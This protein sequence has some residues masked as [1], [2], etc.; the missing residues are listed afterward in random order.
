MNN[1]ARGWPCP[2]L[3]PSLKSLLSLTEEELRTDTEEAL[4][5]GEDA[6]S[7]SMLD[8]IASLRKQTI[9]TNQILITNG[10]SQG[11][12]ICCS[13]FC[14]PGD[15]I[16]VETLSYFYAKYIFE[17]QELRVFRVPPN[18]ER[19]GST[20]GTPM[21]LISL[22]RILE[23]MEN[24][25][26]ILPKLLYCVPVGHNPTGATMKEHHAR[27]LLRIARR[28]SFKIVSDEVYLFLTFD[29]ISH[30][31]PRSLLE[32]DNKD[33]SV[34]LSLNSFSK[35]LGPGLRL[36]WIESSPNNIKFLEKTGFI[37]SGGGLNPFASAI[38]SKFIR[39]GKQEAQIKLL[40]EYIDEY[41][42][43]FKTH[44]R[45]M[46]NTYYSLV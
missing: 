37:A 18:A 11:L 32:Y 10:S 20:G 13:R 3:L 21:D 33:D 26:Q 15:S 17:Q 5:Y 4:Q 1:L 29:S 39:N 6:G 22:E 12:S 42:T 46:S 7:N 30:H 35:I 28:F 36:G 23:E 27:E 38:V 44:N 31:H 8:A 2:T 9:S 24:T 19:D 25:D 14:R 45:G 40:C 41:K 34:V 16:L 43:V